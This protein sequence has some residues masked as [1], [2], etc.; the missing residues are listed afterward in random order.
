MP[1]E[2]RIKAVHIPD[3]AS[4]PSSPEEL[5]QAL[6]KS[7]DRK[8]EREIEEEPYRSAG[9]GRRKRRKGGDER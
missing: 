6:F 2:K 1:R 5:S 4:L 8:L 3:G 9:P 7:A